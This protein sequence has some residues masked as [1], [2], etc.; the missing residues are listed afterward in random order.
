MCP[1]QYFLPNP[2]LEI[3]KIYVEMRVISRQFVSQARMA[4]T[5]GVMDEIRAAAWSAADGFRNTVI[6]GGQQGSPA[7]A[8]GRR[9]GLHVLAP[10]PR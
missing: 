1:S 7:C 6:G 10:A 8:Q 3:G 5:F 9:T 2:G 4:T